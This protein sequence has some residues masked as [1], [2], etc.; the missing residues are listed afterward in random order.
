MKRQVI[1]IIVIVLLLLAMV[2]LV[3]KTKKTIE[4]EKL[5]YIDNL[6]YNFAARLIQ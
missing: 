1:I 2:R 5:S 6:N 4:Q 3:L